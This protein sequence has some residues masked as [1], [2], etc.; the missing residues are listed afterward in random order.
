MSKIEEKCMEEVAKITVSNEE[1]LERINAA[2]EKE[3]KEAS[4]EW[5]IEDVKPPYKATDKWYVVNTE[6][7]KKEEIS[8]SELLKRYD[9]LKEGEITIKEYSRKLEEN[10]TTLERYEMTN[11]IIGESMPYIEECLC[12]EMSLKD[13]RTYDKLPNEVTIYRG[14]HIGEHL[15]HVG[16]SWS[17]DKN[18][19]GFFAWVHY[20]AALS[21]KNLKDRVILKAK[22]LKE[23]IYAYTSQR[24]EAECIVNEDALEDMEI[25]QE[26]SEENVLYAK[27][28]HQL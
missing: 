3:N 1:L 14:A 2:M 22:I 9:V 21:P 18:V 12:H 27:V 6:T 25:Y 24:K 11:K 28:H 8:F 26:F 5:V 16:Q 4:M 20:A 19:A 13:K 7:N 23:H 10:K 17:L 15:G